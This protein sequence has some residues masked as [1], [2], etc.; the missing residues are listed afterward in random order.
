MRVAAFATIAAASVLGIGAYALVSLN[1][2]PSLA[3]VA[4]GE[5]GTPNETPQSEPTASPSFERPCYSQDVTVPYEA[6]RD[7]EEGLPA[8][9][10]DMCI[11]I[12]MHAFQCRF[13]SLEEVALAGGPNFQFSYGV[14]EGAASFWADREREARRK[15]EPA[16]SYMRGLVSVLHMPFCKESQDDGSGTNTELVYYIWPR[17]HCADHRTDQDWK[18]LKRLYTDEQIDQM[19]EGDLYF[20]F[21]VGI[22]ENGDWVYFIAGD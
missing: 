21:R 22:L 7:A 20:G 18:P 10:A 2:T 15:D 17:V 13:E 19:R 14:E 3:P 4:P 11:Q 16:Q 12:L 9:V 8:P 6:I 5:S 1:E